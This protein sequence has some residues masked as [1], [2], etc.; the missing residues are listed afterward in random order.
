MELLVWAAVL[1]GGFVVAAAVGFAV[2]RF[3]IAALP[4]LIILTWL[5]VSP[6]NP[7]DDLPSLAGLT[8]WAAQA[9]GLIGV[10]AGYHWRS[11]DSL[12][13]VSLAAY[14]RRRARRPPAKPVPGS[15]A[16][17]WLGAV[18]DGPEGPRPP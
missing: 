16:A 17:G 13:P 2:G 18:G 4:A 9:G 3:W 12:L 5:F 11:R 10:V 7:D 14:A 1:T 8:L 6:P 15:T